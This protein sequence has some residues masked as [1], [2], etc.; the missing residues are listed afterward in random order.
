LNKDSIINIA[1]FI[2]NEVGVE[3]DLRLINLKE[4]I[5]GQRMVI[6]DLNS[7]D[8]IYLINF[9]VVISARFPQYKMPLNTHLTIQADIRKNENDT[10]IFRQLCKA[11]MPDHTVWAN[12]NAELMEKDFE[13]IVACRGNNYNFF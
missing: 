8:S 7:D 2:F 9:H 4:T 3:D 10:M 6:N 13:I 1:A 5:T 12:R 11:V